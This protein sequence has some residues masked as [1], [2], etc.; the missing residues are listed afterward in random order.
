M[1]WRA[2]ARETLIP[3]PVLN[4]RDDR[5]GCRRRLDLSPKGKRFADERIT[6]EALVRLGKPKFEWDK[7]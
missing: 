1:R 2:C 4:K 5:W 6:S 7:R 3:L